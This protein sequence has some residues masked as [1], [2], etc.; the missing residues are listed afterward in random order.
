MARE[1]SPHEE[2]EP[3]ATVPQLPLHDP[4]Q[5][6]PGLAVSKIKRAIHP[7]PLT[8]LLIG[9]MP[10]PRFPISL[11]YPQ[12]IEIASS[13]RQIH[14][15]EPQEVGMQRIRPVGQ[16]KAEYHRGMRPPGMMERGLPD[17]VNHIR[18]GSQ[19]TQ[20]FDHAVYPLMSRHMQGRFTRGVLR[21]D[22]DSR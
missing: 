18:A 22:S 17:A 9:T 20:G 5:A 12:D 15:G 13:A 16:K 21:I 2:K 1:G 19:V 11:E 3:E 7:R 14:G 4:M 10:W 6:D 8:N